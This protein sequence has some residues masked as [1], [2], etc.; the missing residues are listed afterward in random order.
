MNAFVLS[1]GGNLG[2]LQVGMLKGLLEAGIE[3]GVLVGTSIGSVNAAFLAAGPTPERAEGLCQ[4]WREVR[5]RDIFSWNPLRMIHTIVRRGALFPSE[6][7]RRFLEDRIPYERIEDAAVPLRIIAT[8][9]EN[10][11]PVVLDSGS[12]I[13]AVIASTCL[14]G[15]FPPH[16]IGDHLYL[17]GVLSDQVPLK[18]AIDAGADTVYV[19]AVSNAS[20]PPDTRSSRAILRHALTMLLFPR[21]RLDALGLGDADPK[22][23]IIQVPS[24]G[25]AVALWDM[26]RHH[27][28]H[29]RG[30]PR[31]G[32]V[33]HPLRR[34]CG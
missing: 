16:R 25:A 32:R 5:S 28:P 17:D 24:V 8:D 15:I 9:F 3:P 33:P 7:W 21:I 30:L 19:L 27:D 20:P 22:L 10:G 31:D 2:S 34:G 23:R 29:Q 11:C 18:P 26:S 14:P 6:T 12:V 4:L 13:D 1:G